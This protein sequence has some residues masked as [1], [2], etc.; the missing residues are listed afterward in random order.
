MKEILRSG[1]YG[2]KITDITKKY[3]NT[4]WKKRKLNSIG[5][6]HKAEKQQTEN[7]EAEKYGDHNYKKTKGVIKN[8]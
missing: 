4:I 8:I 6:K 2:Q 1:D 3:L 5:Q 7:F